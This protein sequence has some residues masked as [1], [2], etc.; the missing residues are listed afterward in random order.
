[1]KRS[2]ESRSLV[3]L[4]NG[5]GQE[6]AARELPGVLMLEGIRKQQQLGRRTAADHNRAHERFEKSE[7][8]NRLHPGLRRAYGDGRQDASGK[9]ETGPR[10]NFDFD[11]ARDPGRRQNSSFQWSDEFAP[12]QG[13]SQVR[14]SAGRVRGDNEGGR[15][16]AVGEP[17]GIDPSFLLD[18]ARALIEAVRTQRA[19][20]PK[21]RRD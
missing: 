14:D 20:F 9:W 7:A 18:V 1:V 5:V 4:L 16:F 8:F 10:G 2:N 19:N 11:A 13:V 21:G 3:D 17:E 15:H 12:P 6:R